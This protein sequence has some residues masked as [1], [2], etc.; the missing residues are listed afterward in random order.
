[1]GCFLYIKYILLVLQV[2]S[3]EA[4]EI[5]NNGYLGGNTLPYGLWT[6]D[7]NGPY[8]AAEH[9]AEAET[10]SLLRSQVHFIQ[11]CGVTGKITIAV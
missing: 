11:L 8:G 10:S 6:G 1:M 4:T 5:G 3:K 2:L 9:L 7:L